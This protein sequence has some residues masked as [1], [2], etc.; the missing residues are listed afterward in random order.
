[1]WSKRSETMI[2]MQT[3]GEFLNF[4]HCRK[5]STIRLGK[6]KRSN[7]EAVRPASGSSSDSDSKNDEEHGRIQEIFRQHFEAKFKPLPTSNDKKLIEDDGQ[8]L[9][10]SVDEDEWSGLSST[11]EN[12]VIEVYHTEASI[13]PSKRDKDQWKTF[14]VRH[15]E[16]DISSEPTS[17]LFSLLNLQVRLAKPCPLKNQTQV[18]NK[19]MM[20]TMRRI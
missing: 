2:Y 18:L 8:D 14:M 15:L 11:E 16:E 19:E 5:M 10:G 12:E 9:E 3:V 6:R 7:R 13:S 4:T 17:D 20:K 1:M